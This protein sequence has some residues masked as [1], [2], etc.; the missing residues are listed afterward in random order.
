MKTLAH[1]SFDLVFPPKTIPSLG[2]ATAF[3]GLS[4]RMMGLK[5]G[6]AIKRRSDV[7]RYLGFTWK[8]LERQ[9]GEKVM[10]W[11]MDKGGENGTLMLKEACE[12][13]GITITFTGTEAHQ[14]NGE[15]ERW[16]RLVFDCVHAHQ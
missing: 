3:L 11:H 15:Q 5:L 16:F 4:V 9:M 8:Y 14:Q 13:E 7:A 1:V 12:Q 6:Y 10:N 2:G